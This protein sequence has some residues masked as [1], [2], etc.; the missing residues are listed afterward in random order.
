MSDLND[1]LI[2]GEGVS[3]E[4]KRCGNAPEEDVFQ[5][6]CSFANRQGGSILLGVLD[7]G[8][9]EGIEGA[10]LKAIERNIVNVVNNPNLFNMPPAVEFE[11]IPL[12]EDCSVLRVWVPMGPS[13][14]RF[15]GMVYDRMADVDVKLQNDAQITALALR[16]Q[17]YYT[18]RQ[19]FPW[20]AK[21]D[22]RLDL[23]PRVRAMAAATHPG[24]SWLQL[25][26]DELLRSARLYARDR[27]TGESGFTLAAVMLLGCDDV[28]LDVCP[29]Y[30]TDALLRRADPYRY[31]DRVTVKTNLVEAYDELTAF[32]EK[33][34]PDTFVLD[35]SQRVSARGIIVRELVANM[36]IHREFTSPYIARLE[37]DAEG[38]RTRNASRSLYSG[39]ITPSNLDPT[40]KN[41][42]IANFFTQIGRSEELGSGTRNLYRFS[43]LY[44]GEDPVLADGDF[45]E[46]FVPVPRVGQ[47][48]F[49]DGLVA[50]EGSAVDGGDK[51]SS[52]ALGF[53]GAVLGML[54]KA[55][56]VS[57]ADVA[58]H[59]G[60]S[61]RTARRHLAS[62]VE[63]GTLKTIGGGR[64]TVYAL[65]S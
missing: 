57:S 48:F 43:R 10:R 3:I 51:G 42:I 24:H 4:F 29:A 12:A 23:L 59:T 17:G 40:P 31:D 27:A 55:G 9:P 58:N 14:Y 25:S 21:A 7:D 13:V 28:I 37:I 26:D 39:P 2:Q 52:G 46:A 50:Q 15:K 49:G 45:F 5:T 32:C 64:S 34:L 41:P 65:A 38:I 56:A 62:M 6:V 20:V 47:P 60:V 18:E 44:T 54:K 33:W 8:T 16:K 53:E 1:Y 30:R 19:V 22:L 35:G 11:R 63:A 61:A 36:L